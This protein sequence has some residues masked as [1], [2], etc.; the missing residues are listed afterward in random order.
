MQSKKENKKKGIYLHIFFLLFMLLLF[1]IDRITKISL[2]GKAGCLWFLCITGTANTGS[3]LGIF[4]GSLI[5]K[6]LVI[7]LSLIVIAIVGFFYSIEK[8]N[9]FR[10]ASAFVLAGIG[11]NLFDRLFYGNVLDWLVFRFGLFSF[12]L[13]DCY[14][15][16]GLILFVFLFA[17]E[18]KK[19]KK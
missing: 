18:T 5:F 7:I 6:F 12:N 17:K 9:N 11:G 13:A 14:I 8:G 1:F 19:H 16:A 4:S 10:L 3:L 15:W 2:Y